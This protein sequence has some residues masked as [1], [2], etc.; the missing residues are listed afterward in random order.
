MRK[1]P[2]SFHDRVLHNLEKYVGVKDQIAN[3]YER[4]C[5]VASTALSVASN[6]ETISPI[7]VR[8][9]LVEISTMSNGSTPSCSLC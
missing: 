7:C 6:D 5:H 9:C 8:K 2:S 4:M 3:F 1:I